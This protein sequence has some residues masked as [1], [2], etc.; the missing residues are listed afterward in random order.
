MIS[1]K[2]QTGSAHVV[3]IVVLII[4]ILGLLGFVFWQN[5]LQK[6]DTVA[7]ETKTTTTTTAPATTQ[8]LDTTKPVDTTKYVVLDTWHVKFAA[9]TD[10][11]GVTWAA[12][13]DSSNAIGFSTSNLTA[14]DQLCNAE[15]GAAGVLERSTDA[16]SSQ[17]TGTTTTLVNDGKPI[18]GY[19]YAFEMPNGQHCANTNPSDYD[20][21]LKLQKLVQTLVEA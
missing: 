6:K 9:P 15:N 19:Y 17:T 4:A 5:F 20:E 2:N 8:Q 13:K 10:G 7:T 1:R 14:D 12:S 21:A 16:I 18:G 11:T 3:I